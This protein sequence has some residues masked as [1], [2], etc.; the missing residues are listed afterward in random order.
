M[1]TDITTKVAC[2]L[3]PYKS[4]CTFF[5]KNALLFL[6]AVPVI[7]KGIKDARFRQTSGAAGHRGIEAAGVLAAP[8]KPNHIVHLCS[9]AFRS[10]R[11]AAT[12]NILGIF[13]P[14]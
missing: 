8:S 14:E 10:C 6:S 7:P 12:S 11:R 9:G 1:F 2:L 13:K 3:T 4:C 5:F